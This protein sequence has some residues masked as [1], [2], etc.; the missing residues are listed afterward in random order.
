MSAK[1]AATIPAYA[2]KLGIS[3]MT[4]KDADGNPQ[5]GFAHTSSKAQQADPK[6]PYQMPLT[7]EE[8]DIMDGKKGPE[9]AKVMKIVVAHGN[10]F[11]AERLVDLG[12]APHCSLYTGTDYMKPMIDLFQECAEAGLKAYAPYTVNPRCYD[13]YNVNNNAQDLELIYEGYRYQR[14]LDWVHAQLGAPDLNYRSCM[15]YVDEIGNKPPPGTYVA[16]AES[17]AINYGNSALGLRTNRNA[18]GMELLCALLGKAPLF[19]LMTDEGRMANWLVE[20]KTSKEPDWGVIGSA[21][22]YKVVD[23]VPFITG[24]DKYLGDKVTNDN[25]HH[26]KIMGSATAACGAVGLYHVENVTPDA[27]EKGRDLLAEGYQTY[28]IDDAEQARVLGTFPVEWEG[29]PK[30]PTACFIGCPHNT[31]QEILTWGKKVTEAVEKRGLKTGAVPTIMFT[32]NKVRDHLL[33]AEPELFGKMHAAGMRF[34]NMC[35]VSYA[36]MK[37]FSERTFGVTNSP[38]TRNYYP[39]VRYLKDDDLLEVICTGEIPKDA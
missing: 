18:G 34:T 13:V 20:V 19:G 32:P 35:Q 10:A 33:E 22:G 4:A 16:W 31:Y 37:G 5:P 1:E 3:D 7:K 28:V 12:G 26:L 29:R 21:I 38:K 14:D 6:A 27:K 24:L 36:G 9:L 30:K 25:M 8:Q 15:C 17:S 11:G 39:H 23:G 2:G